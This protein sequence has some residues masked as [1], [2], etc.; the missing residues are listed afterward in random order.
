MASGPF[1]GPLHLRRSKL[2]RCPLPSDTHTTPLLSMSAPRGPKPGN[3]T[4]YT[5]ASAVAGGFAPGSSR[6]TAPLP[7]NTPTV[8][9]TEPS[10][11]LGMRKT[12]VAVAD[13]PA[14]AD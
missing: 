4:L 5:S 7:A 10:T 1:N 3:G 12:V 2:P 13:I 14:I 9:H 11:G 6:T 8:P